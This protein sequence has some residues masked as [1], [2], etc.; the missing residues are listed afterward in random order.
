MG[1][2]DKPPTQGF[3]IVVLLVIAAILFA[4]FWAIPEW[5]EVQNQYSNNGMS[6]VAAVLAT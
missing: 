2:F 6:A 3:W 1:N 5:N 4:V